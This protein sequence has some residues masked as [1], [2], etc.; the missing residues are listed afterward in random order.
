MC[1]LCE[2]FAVAQGCYIASRVMHHRLL[3]RILHAPMAF[4][5]TTPLGELLT[6]S[7]SILNGFFIQIESQVV[8]YHADE[9]IAKW[10][11]FSFLNRF[12]QLLG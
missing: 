10:K 7:K 12:S 1:A 8:D 5:D 11:E 3:D 9:V 4:F 6:A 2:A